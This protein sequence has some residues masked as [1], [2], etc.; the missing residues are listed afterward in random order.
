M[1]DSVPVELSATEALGL[2]ARARAAARAPQPVPAWYGATFAVGFS[3]YGL[4]IGYALWAD[5]SWLG[6][7][8]GAVFA[9]VSGAL[10]A[11]V[12]RRG[13][14]AR[15]WTPGLGGP[16][17]RW[18]VLVFAGALVVA[19]VVR[20]LGADPRGT[21]GSAGVTAGVLFWLTTARVNARI[22]REAEEV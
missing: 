22:R 8:L 15:G 18:V 14:V 11:V 3:L 9:A 2:A 6:G 7:V 20:L 17:T 1:T 19:A 21:F 12:T 10:G 13:G 4:G 16:M 5:L